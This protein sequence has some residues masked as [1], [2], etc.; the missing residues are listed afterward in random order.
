VFRI[1]AKLGPTPWKLQ[2]LYRTVL[3]PMRCITTMDVQQRQLMPLGESFEVAHRVRD[4]IDFV[5]CAR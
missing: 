5:V 4:S 1:Q 3:F 2:T